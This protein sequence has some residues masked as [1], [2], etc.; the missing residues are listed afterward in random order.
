M[1]RLPRPQS[2]PDAMG[3]VPSLKRKI[4]PE[5]DD[6]EEQPAKKGPASTGF[7]PKPLQASRNATNANAI[8]S[9]S[10]S[11][12]SSKPAAASKP[13]AVMP[14][15]LTRPRP[16][17]AA[18][19]TSRG[20]SAPPVST[21][22]VRKPS[23]SR[24]PAALGKRTAS[25]GATA[26]A[27][28][29]DVITNLHKRLATLESARTQDT[30]RLASLLE[31]SAAAA[32]SSSSAAASAAVVVDPQTQAELLAAQT[33]LASTTAQLGSATRSCSPCKPSSGRRRGRSARAKPLRRTHGARTSRSKRTCLQGRRRS[34]PAH[35]ESSELRRALAREREEGEI[36][37]RRG[38][39]LLR[40]A[41]DD[42]EECEGKLAKVRKEL[43]GA[44]SGEVGMQERC[45]V[46]E[47]RAERLAGEV[48]QLQAEKTA[49]AV[50]RAGWDVEREAWEV[51]K[52]RG[53]EE[54][55]SLH[56]MVME[57][58]GNIRVFCRVRPVL[59]DEEAGAEIAY[60][61]A[62][63]PYPSGQKEIVLSSTGAEREW[64][65]GMGNKARREVWGFGFDRVFTPASTQ[66]D[67]FA[68]I[69]QLAQSC[70]DGYNVC[71][72]AYGQTGSGKSWTMEGGGTEET[73]GMIP[74]AVAQVFRVAE[75]LKDKGWTYTMEGQ[76]LEI[77]QKGKARYIHVDRLI[78][79]KIRRTKRHR[80]SRGVVP[81]LVSYLPPS[82]PQTDRQTIQTPPGCITFQSAGELQTKGL[83]GYFRNSARNFIWRDPT[84][85]H[86]A[87]WTIPE[88]TAA[89][90]KLVE[91]KS[92]HQS[93][94]GWKSTV[95]PDVVKA[96]H[97]ANPDANP[98]KD[99]TKL[100]SK[101]EDL[102]KTF[103][104]Y[105]FVEKFSGSGWDEDEK[106]ASNT[107]SI[108]RIL[109]RYT[110]RSTR[111]A[112]RKRVLS[113][114]SSMNC[115]MASETAR[116]ANML[117]ISANPASASPRRTLLPPLSRLPPPLPP[118]LPPPRI[119]S[120]QD[121]STRPAM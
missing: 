57:L 104:L 28:A 1:S 34:R 60:P 31:S 83:I 79:P 41:K 42:L 119:S 9:T 5:E 12:T 100:I 22:T 15:P 55:R 70:T 106:H 94:N 14:R 46:L 11:T 102:K 61:D 92:T 84:E 65:A 58:K 114:R 43:E 110:A 105:L 19:P 69:S 76:F 10:A 17:V 36:R 113:T 26:T 59:S 85:P 88:V 24:V 35:D 7:R 6:I 109:S 63:L 23:S 121:P 56:G 101:L 2:S 78:L 53:E 67:L 90:S 74:R 107:P 29:P 99:Q 45:R 13:A 98:P 25:G 86:N 32:T 8:A 20:A 66:A 71:I 97:A 93:G 38:E 68:E 81:Y 75:E 39:R 91:R 18:R 30:E 47:G 16:P 52:R 48:A 62:G 44:V 120:L 118:L 72:F 21:V 54:R 87:K 49:W 82:F 96:V 4:I 108:S 89:L 64:D 77:V 115:T 40:E 37:A 103:E 116:P 112:S 117:F 50:E 27:A 3:F 95:W 33:Q 111:D 51:E 73:Q 80:T